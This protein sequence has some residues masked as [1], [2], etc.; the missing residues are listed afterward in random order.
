MLKLKELNFIDVKEE[1]VAI[2]SIPK[3]ENGFENKYFNVTFEE[4]K[5]VVIPKLINNSNGIDLEEGY[6][7][8]TYYFLWDD[9]KI[10]GLFKIRHY[11]NDFLKK[12]PGHIGYCIL[13]E[14]RKQG[15]A[16]EGLKLAIK[17][18]K[19]I[20]PENE[21]YMSVNKDNLASLKVQEKCGAVVVS[22]TADSTEFLTRI[23][24]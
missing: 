20:I 17:E 4:F 24:L 2:T 23:K 19:K 11:L 15:Y 21:I 3:M 22:E 6:V 10:V 9:D 14:Y 5:N 18:A 12:G 7:P 8:D 1:Y 16:T 13:K